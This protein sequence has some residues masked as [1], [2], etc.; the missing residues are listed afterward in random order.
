MDKIVSARG[1]LMSR[2]LILI[3]IAVIFCSLVIG[4]AST[5]P[6]RRESLQGPRIHE[7]ELSEGQPRNFGEEEAPGVSGPPA[8]PAEGPPTAIEQGS[9]SPRRFIW[10]DKKG[11]EKAWDNAPQR[12]RD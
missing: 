4:C 5:P 12:S 10:R 11:S 2:I 7:E 8:P 9:R 6:Q 3:S 1:I